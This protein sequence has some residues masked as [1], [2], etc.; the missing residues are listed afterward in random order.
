[1]FASI[2]LAD[3]APRMLF[4]Q[5][6]RT[7]RSVYDAGFS[8]LGS[9]DHCTSRNEILKNRITE[10]SKATYIR[11]PTLADDK[12]MT[13]VH[14]SFLWLFL[15]FFLSS[16]CFQRAIWITRQRLFS[17]KS[18]KYLHFSLPMNVAIAG[19]DPSCLKHGTPTWSFVALW[20]L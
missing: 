4:N 18:K 14:F 20:I 11:C 7:D 13:F 16:S 5:L 19:E 8:C 2:K 1:M 3:S 10:I 6:R 9:Q 12:Q 15:S 17:G